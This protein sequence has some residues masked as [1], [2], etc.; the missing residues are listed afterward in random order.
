MVTATVA[1]ELKANFKFYADKAAGGDC[2][3]I[4]R[5]R[6][7]NLVLISEEEYHNLV[8]IKNE[9]EKPGKR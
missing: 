5:P 8:R 4:T 3:I 2:I 6:Q 7:K 9:M 1:T